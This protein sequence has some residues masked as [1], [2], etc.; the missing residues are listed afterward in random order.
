M[1]YLTCYRL[2]ILLH[3]ILYKPGFNARFHSHKLTYYEDLNKHSYTYITY[4]LA[5][6]HKHIFTHSQ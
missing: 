1:Q 5:G 2:F 4:T 6:L 3:L